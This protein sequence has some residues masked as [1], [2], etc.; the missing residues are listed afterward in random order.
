MGYGAAAA[1]EYEFFLFSETPASVREKNYRGLTNLTPGYFGYSVLRSSVHAEL[2]QRLV[3]L[4]VH[5]AA[6]NRIAEITRSEGGQ[7]AVVFLPHARGGLAEQ[8]E[9]EIGRAS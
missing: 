5:R 9:L 3:K 1:A 8:E 2:Q 7:A 4:G 6:Q